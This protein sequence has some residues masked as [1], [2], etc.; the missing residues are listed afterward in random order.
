MEDDLKYLKELKTTSIYVKWKRTSIFFPI[1]NDLIL[2]WKMEENLNILA[3]GRR[4]KFISIWNMTQN[5]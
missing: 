3:N 2:F 5:L 1:K 4:P